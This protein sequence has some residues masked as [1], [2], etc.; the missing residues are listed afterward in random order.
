M[1]MDVI[2]VAPTSERGEYFRNNVWWWRP[3]WNYCCEVSEEARSVENGH[4]NDGDG[5]DGDGSIALAKALLA[6]IN[7]GRTKAYQDEYTK[8]QG[9]QPRRA[10]TL[11]DSTGIRSEIG[12]AHV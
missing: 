4:T 1:G 5:L 8:W 11:C 3:L 7:S 6:E 12:R 2:G 10:C 9:E